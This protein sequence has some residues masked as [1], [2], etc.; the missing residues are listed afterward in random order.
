MFVKYVLLLG[1]SSG[2]LIFT[3]QFLR[4]NWIFSKIFSFILFSFFSHKTKYLLYHSA[5]QPNQNI[6]LNHLNPQLKLNVFSVSF[7]FLTKRNSICRLFRKLRTVL[8]NSR[9]CWNL[10][11]KVFTVDKWLICRYTYVVKSQR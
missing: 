2:K 5:L 3:Q 1:H 9:I 11:L 6:L 8:Y 4:Q 10:M 7:F